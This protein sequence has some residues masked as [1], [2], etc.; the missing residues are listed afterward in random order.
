MALSIKNERTDHVVRRYA[1][2]HNVSCTRAVHLAVT[3]ALRREGHAV[4]E[5]NADKFEDFMAFVRD[6]Q[7][8]L[9]A[10]PDLDPRSADELLYDS[11]GL[12]K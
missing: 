7:Q 2:L 3:D 9:A 4:D 11:D 8:Q 1:K 5:E 12:P 10:A 6:L